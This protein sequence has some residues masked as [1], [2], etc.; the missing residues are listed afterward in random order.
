MV[1]GGFDRHKIA[2]SFEFACDV[3]DAI[4]SRL[5]AILPQRPTSPFLASLQMA[6][7]PLTTVTEIQVSYP[8]MPVDVITALTVD[9]SSFKGNKV[10][11]RTSLSC[12]R[13][14]RLFGALQ[15]PNQPF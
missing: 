14:H 5:P 12:C 9:R 13:P 4:I 3:A 1:L 10:M 8:L 11:P 2:Y 15:L 7:Y 6:D